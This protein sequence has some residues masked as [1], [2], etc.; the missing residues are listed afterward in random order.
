MAH[1]FAISNGTSAVSGTIKN[2]GTR[3]VIRIDDAEAVC[4]KVNGDGR[5]QVHVQTEGCGWDGI[6]TTSTKEQT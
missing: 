1:Q 3:L 5:P 2:D 4:L 6:I